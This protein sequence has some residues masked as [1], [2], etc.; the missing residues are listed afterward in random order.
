M[1]NLLGI[2]TSKMRNPPEEGDSARNYQLI[3][4]E[5]TRGEGFHRELAA[6]LLVFRPVRT[7]FVKIFQT[8][9]IPGSA[10]LNHIY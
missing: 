3:D 1:G 7:K 9:T 8:V 4:K 5:S 6:Y 2:T 10:A